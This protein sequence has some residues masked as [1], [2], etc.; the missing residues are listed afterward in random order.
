MNHR[1]EAWG[2]LKGKVNNK[3]STVIKNV[4]E[5]MKTTLR[6]LHIEDNQKD[7][8]LIASMIEAGDVLADITL[9]ETREDFIAALDSDGFNLILSDYTIPSYDG[10]SA[11]KAAKERSPD[12]PF[13]FVSGTIGE[14]RAV[15]A[16]KTGATDY[17]L[18]NNMQRL[19]P[20]VKRALREAEGILLRKRLE[21]TLV[22][23]EEKYRSIF[24]NAVEGIFQTKSEG[25]FI[26]V[27]PAMARI[28]GFPSP[29]E[30]MTSVTNIGEQLYLQPGDRKRYQRIL[31]EHG[32]VKDF[33][34]Q[35]YR[36]DG[37]TIWTSTS[38]RTVRDGT[39]KHIYFEGTVG[40]ITDRKKAEEELRASTRKLRRN[41]IGTI[42]VISMMLE[43]RD[44]YTGGH[45]RR[46]SRLAR[47]IAQVMGLTKD[48]IDSIRMAGTIH[49]IGK[50][51]VPAEI[52]V[53]PSKLTDI[54]MQLI[55]IHPQTGYDILRVADLPHPI[56]KIVLQHHERLNG[57]GY[58]QGLKGGEILLEA[59]ILSVADVVEAMAS[60][61]PYRPALGMEA[62][63]EEIEKNRDI[64]FNTTV[65]DTCLLLFKEK[66]FSF[67]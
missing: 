8:E 18:K 45:Q 4:R 29:E 10:M 52:L 11:L 43:T 40:D 47:S 24:E 65:V 39:G 53:K 32:E 60:H 42:Q 50:M 61:R 33:E 66:G 20:A 37:T 34:A 36:K 64:F 31:Q 5:A 57:S 19:I 62:A 28:H 21:E 38:A 41:L 56:A 44:P 46:V 26:T 63:L 12:T 6:I 22:E 1:L 16:L 14:E 49:D 23:S 9:V 55:K 27:N 2:N 25:C 15:E 35:V 17:V 13:I 58:P 48:V 51:S 30:M 59:Q 54:E 7:A 67:E 3:R